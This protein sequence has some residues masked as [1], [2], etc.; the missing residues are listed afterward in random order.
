MKTSTKA[1]LLSALVIPGAGHIYLKKYFPGLIL[2]GVSLSAVY[3]LVSKITEQAMQA[4]TQIE[5]GSVSLDPVA[6]NDLII[7]QQAGADGQLLNIATI[8]II[9]CWVVGMID[10]YRVANQQCPDK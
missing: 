7:S 1:V 8:A 6:I 5:N 10:A 3:V 2:I 4:I 9:I